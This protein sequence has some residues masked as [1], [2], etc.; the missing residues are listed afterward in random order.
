MGTMTMKDVDPGWLR[1]LASED[2]TAPMPGQSIRPV[3]GEHLLALHKERVRQRAQMPKHLEGDDLE[4]R[5][6]DGR[7]LE[8]VLDHDLDG[9]KPYLILGKI[10]EGGMGIV[11]S[12]RQRSTMR[13]VAIKA[14][15]RDQRRETYQAIFQEECQITA[16]LEHPHIPPVYDAGADFMVMKRLT[17]RS[18]ED[19]LWEDD[20]REHLALHVEALLKVC[21]AVAYAHSRGVV[22]RDLKGEN[23]MV[24]DYGEVWLMDWGLAAGFAP[25]RDGLWLAPPVSCRQDMCAGTP[26]CVA[27][28]VACADPSAI[29]PGIDLFMLGALLYRTLCGHYPYEAGDATS[30]LRLAA[31]R[32]QQALLIRV[33]NAPFRLVQAAERSMAWDPQDRGE[34]ADFIDDLR[35]WLHTSGAATEAK[36]LV[37]E[38][39]VLLALDETGIDASYRNLSHALVTAER[40]VQL[41]PELREAH[42]VAREARAAFSAV[43][44]GAGD[45]TLADLIRKGFAV[46]SAP[47][48]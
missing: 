5:F 36:R 16:G 6:G 46:P 42:E 33:P 31:K 14:L 7:N 27:P 32:N 45:K 25:D 39:R 21:D 26:L 10:G 1:A 40:A 13:Q 18:L 48:R 38:A 17:G 34:I 44:E 19:R 15:H 4:V 12:A 23:I 29:G 30:S 37:A 24:G 22:H 8:D 3:Y 28:E 41:A 2:G 11:L 35:T 43:A 47:Q 20:A 9:S